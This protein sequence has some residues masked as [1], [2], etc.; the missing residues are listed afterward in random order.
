MGPPPI[1]SSYL[2]RGPTVDWL[3][4][5][6]VLLNVWKVHIFRRWLWI[7][8]VPNLYN[9]E[10][11]IYCLWSILSSFEHSHCLKKCCA[12]KSVHN[13]VVNLLT[14]NEAYAIGMF[15]G[16]H[17]QQ[18]TILCSHMHVYFSTTWKLQVYFRNLIYCTLSRSIYRKQSFIMTLCLFD[19]PK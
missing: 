17:P 13:S 5:L 16:T 8:T 12:R 14:L 2:D 15:L 10:Q 19:K 11:K 6:R 1:F 9:M 3:P 4:V 7:S 18:C